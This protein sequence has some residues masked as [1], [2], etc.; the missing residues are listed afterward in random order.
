MGDSR[1]YILDLD[2]LDRFKRDL[3][4]H[5][6]YS[7]VVANMDISIEDDYYQFDLT[8]S[9]GETEK[10]MANRPTAVILH[11]DN[12][13][14]MFN[15][16][17]T[18]EGETG[19]EIIYTMNVPIEDEGMLW[20]IITFSHE[21]DDG[22]EGENYDIDTTAVMVPVGGGGGPIADDEDV[23]EMFE[24]AITYDLSNCSLTNEQHSIMEGSGYYTEVTVPSGGY[25]TSVW[26]I[27]GSNDITSKVWDGSTSVNIP[28]VTD[29]VSMTFHAEVPA[30][31]YSVTFGN[32]DSGVVIGN[33]SEAIEG[34]QE[35]TNTLTIDKEYTSQGYHF[36]DVHITMNGDSYDY[37]LNRYDD[38]TRIEL[39]GMYATGDIYWETISIN[40]K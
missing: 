1:H 8:L 5:N 22:K 35:Y 7:P 32:V 27:M 34:G 33:S 11:Y 36:G 37:L 12:S 15:L 18:E 20:L 10:I 9:G 40:T 38:N 19:E 16:L 24:R 17:S 13:D 23:D 2:G 21:A 28:V 26:V 4:A 25:L 3:D 39:S 31:N 29:N 6:A 30:T 14:L